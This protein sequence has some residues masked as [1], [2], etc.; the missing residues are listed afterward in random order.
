MRTGALTEVLTSRG[1]Q[2]V[3]WTSAFDHFAK[4]W[5]WQRT[6]ELYRPGVGRV[7]GNTERDNVDEVAYLL[8]AL[9]VLRGQ[10]PG[11]R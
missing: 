6:T 11:G 2:V 1:H 3:W 10:A 4:R 9:V 8:V 5:L 7:I